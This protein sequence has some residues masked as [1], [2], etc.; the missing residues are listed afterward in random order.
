MES[1]KAPSPLHARKGVRKTPGFLSFVHTAQAIRT[2]LLA[3][4]TTTL[5]LLSF[6]ARPE[7]PPP[8]AGGCSDAPCFLRG[9]NRDLDCRNRSIQ[10]K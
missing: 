2:S 7:Q 5:F 1:E 8:K 10:I 4:A 3:K 9:K 6:R